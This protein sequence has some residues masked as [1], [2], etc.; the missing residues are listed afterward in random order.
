MGN[1]TV[2]LLQQDFLSFNRLIASNYSDGVASSWEL[3]HIDIVKT[4]AI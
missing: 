4:T 1:V 3:L 2:Q